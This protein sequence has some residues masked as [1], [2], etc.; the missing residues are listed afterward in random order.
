MIINNEISID[1]SFIK[2]DFI[3]SSGPGG[4]NVNKVATACQLRF[5]L[6]NCDAISDRVKARIIQFNPSKINSAGE[7]I[8]EARKYR[9][10][11]RNKEDA[12]DRLREIILK[13]LPEPTPRKRKKISRAVKKRRLENK[14]HKSEV[15]QN[16]KPPRW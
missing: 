6:V 3:R 16:R 10:Q 11:L 14:R 1:E 12:Y 7:L 15:K 8:I 5:D 13:R 9:S 4:Q 2:C